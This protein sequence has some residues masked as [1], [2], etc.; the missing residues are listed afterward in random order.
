MSY[1]NG[2]VA[3]GVWYWIR[4]EVELT[5]RHPVVAFK[6]EGSDED[7]KDSR[8]TRLFRCVGFPALCR[9]RGRSGVHGRQQVQ[10]HRVSRNLSGDLSEWRLTATPPPPAN[11][12]GAHQVIPQSVTG[13]RLDDYSASTATGNTIDIWGA[14]GTGA[15]S[16]VFNNAGVIPTGSY[17][18]AVSFGAFCVTASAPSSGSPVNLQPCNGSAGQAW[19]AVRSGNGYLGHPASNPSL[20]MDVY[21]NGNANGT[22]VI[23]W[24]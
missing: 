23:V 5:R 16:W 24:T 2:T 15:Q 7:E 19:N 13:S 10:L 8:R 21:A 18:I 12:N 20:C 11:L 1:R 22:P 6:N 9:R 4:L 17:N 3:N 14:N